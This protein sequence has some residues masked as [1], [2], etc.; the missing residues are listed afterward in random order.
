MATINLRDLYPVKTD[1]LGE[2]I[3]GKNGEVIENPDC[4]VEVPDS[5][6]EAF[7]AGLTKEIAN[8]YFKEQHEENAY[9]RRV[10][11]HKAHYSL[12]QDDGIENH[13]AEKV[14]DP[15]E[16]ISEKLTREQL[17]AAI[18]SLP[19]K[20]AKRVYAYFIL[21]MS[22]TEIALSEGVNNSQITRSI[23]KALANLKKI[24]RNLI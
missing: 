2:P 7:R 10:Y 18:D 13:V 9:Q 24:L 19:E 15:F 5:D 17:L 11:W 12:D 23:D 20:Q 21:E 6:V 14:P 4:F 8:V 22:M 3:K 16:I 1:E